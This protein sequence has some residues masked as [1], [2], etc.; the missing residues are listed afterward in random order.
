MQDVRIVPTKPISGADLRICFG[1]E[2]VRKGVHENSP[3]KNLNNTKMSEI[4]AMR[5]ANGDWFAFE[6]HG[7]LSLPLF[8]SSHDA[9][10]ARLRNVGMLLF[11]PVALDPGLL[12]EISPLGGESPVDFCMVNDPFAGL[13]HGAPMDRAELSSMMNDPGERQTVPSNGNISKARGPGKTS[14]SEWWN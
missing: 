11:E 10:M 9:T 13:V 7:R 8:H 6:G 4:Y 2:L 3:E 14:Q 12:S 1:K 5:R